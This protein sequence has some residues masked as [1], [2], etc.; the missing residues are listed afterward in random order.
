MQKM[1][2]QIGRG[3][4]GAE[5]SEGREFDVEETVHEVVTCT[6][7]IEPARQRES[8]GMPNK[9]ACGM[10]TRKI[11]TTVVLDRGQSSMGRCEQICKDTRRI[12][13]E[14]GDH[15]DRVV[16]YSTRGARDHDKEWNRDHNQ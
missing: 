2:K 16:K 3:M 4:C 7:R 6:D 13:P 1:S 15:R 10:N 12:N 5:S 8:D 9:E 14:K 11:R